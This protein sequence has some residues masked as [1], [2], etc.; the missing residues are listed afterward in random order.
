M[1]A[2]FFQT[3]FPD[4][5]LAATLFIEEFV[6][7][8]GAIGIV[9]FSSSAIILSNLVVVDSASDRQYLKNLLPG[10]TGGST[11]IGGGILKAIQV[12]RH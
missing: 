8:G 10:G 1:I 4:M 9:Q 6:P 3:R 11:G 2:N 7:D 5:I 12:S